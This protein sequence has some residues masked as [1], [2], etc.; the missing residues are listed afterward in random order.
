MNQYDYTYAVARIKANELSLLGEND[1]EQLISGG[2]YDFSLRK[3]M[4]SGFGEINAGE[5]YS[6]MLKRYAKKTWDFLNEVMPY[7]NDLDFLI[8]KNDM[9][10]LKAALKSIVAQQD[11]SENYIFPTINSVEE[12]KDLVAKRKF[13]DLPEYMVQVA[14]QAYG[15]LTE[16]GNGQVADAIIDKA[17][18]DIILTKAKE[19]KVKL[20]RDVAEVFCATANIKNLYRCILTNKS[21]EYMRLSVSECDTLSKEDMIQAALG[22]KEAFLNALLETPY[23]DAKKYLETSF[24]SFEKW[25]DD[26]IMQQVKPEKANYFGMGPLIAYYIAKETELKTIRIIL[27]AKKNDL[28]AD[29][30]RE[31][32]R[33]LYV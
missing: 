12:I 9:H 26:L 31:R 10:A 15:V 14:K 3:L 28:S 21:E 33:S 7:D 11:Q 32:V 20:C 22:G 30:I 6:A 13:D 27:A 8:V 29:V 24:S 4:E 1:I 25:C 5:D 16:T 2:D 23:E 19:T 18:L 17:T